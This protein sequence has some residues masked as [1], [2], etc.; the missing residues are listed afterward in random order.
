MAQAQLDKVR[1]YTHFRRLQLSGDLPTSSPMTQIVDAS[2]DTGDLGSVLAMGY[3][4][5]DAASFGA[6][7]TDQFIKTWL[8]NTQFIHAAFE[9]DATS[10][11]AR[12]QYMILNLNGAGQAGECIRAR[13]FLMAAAAGGNTVNGAHIEMRLNGTS[14][15]GVGSVTGDANAIRATLSVDAGAGIT[16]TMSALRLDSYFGQTSTGIVGG[17]ISLWDVNSTNKMPFFLDISGIAAGTSSAWKSG[18]CSS[19]TGGGLRVNYN[20]TIYYIPLG[21]ACS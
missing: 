5:N 7:G 10:G 15:G 17:F 16:G 1:D 21:T 4:Y 8:A 19:F 11:T 14:T 20:G 13:T 6:S 3:H 18:T 9:S 12:G 2:A